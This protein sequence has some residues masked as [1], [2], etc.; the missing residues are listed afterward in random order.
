MIW[1]SLFLFETLLSELHKF[2]HII[3]VCNLYYTYRLRDYGLQEERMSGD[4]NCQASLYKSN[5]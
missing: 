4:G 1:I 5:F 2:L 3:I